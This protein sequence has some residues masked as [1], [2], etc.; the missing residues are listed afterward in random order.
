MGCSLYLYQRVRAFDGT[1]TD[2]ILGCPVVYLKGYIM[3]IS[4]NQTAKA[5][6]NNNGDFEKATG[7]LNLYLPWNDGTNKKIGAIA[8][9]DTKATDK[10]LLDLI[11][12]NPSAAVEMI[13][14]SLIIEYRSSNAVLPAGAC[15][16]FG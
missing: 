8:L 6:T 5:I 11:E 3:A 15:F 13:K 2:P 14:N 7:F 12:K 4:F 1:K 9:R 10:M 16:N